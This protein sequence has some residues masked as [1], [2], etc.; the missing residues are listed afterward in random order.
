M[1]SGPFGSALLKSELAE[2]GSPLLGIDNVFVER[3][4]TNFSRFVDDA[5]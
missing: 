2:N 4:V 5:N 1:R 3:F